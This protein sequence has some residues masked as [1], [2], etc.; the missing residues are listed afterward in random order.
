MQVEILLV[1][2]SPNF[3]LEITLIYSNEKKKR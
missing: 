1:S 3:T 2:F